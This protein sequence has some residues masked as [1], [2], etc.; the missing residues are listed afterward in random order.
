MKYKSA[1]ELF[2][3]KDYEQFFS[4][5]QDLYQKELIMKRSLFGAHLDDVIFYFQD[6]KARFYSSR[7]QQKILLFLA[8]MG[9]VELLKDQ[10]FLPVLIFDDFISDFDLSRLESIISIIAELENQLIFTS[11]YYNDFLQK[12]LKPLIPFEIFLR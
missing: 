11:P 12:L 5:N 8:K 2:L 10:G 6:V 7:G 4:E 1:L 9:Q 3:E